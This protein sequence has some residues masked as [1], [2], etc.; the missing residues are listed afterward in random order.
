MAFRQE[1]FDTGLAAT[2]LGALLLFA[3]LVGGFLVLGR[4]SG[5]VLFG[6]NIDP[7][8]PFDVLPPVA[9]SEPA[10]P[11]SVE[12][13]PPVEPAAPAPESPSPEAP[14]PVGPPAASPPGT[15]DEPPSVPPPGNPPEAVPS[16]LPEVPTLGDTVADPVG[17]VGRTATA[18]VEGAGSAVGDLV[19]T[20]LDLLS[21]DSP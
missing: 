21:K 15:P 18:T 20:A 5:N 1:H 17:T 19:E 7:G 4:L 2:A 8:D 6:T 11:V 3:L 16:P 9:L 14:A 10:T 13:P 12:A